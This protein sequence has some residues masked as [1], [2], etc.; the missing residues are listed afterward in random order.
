MSTRSLLGVPSPCVDVCRM[1]ETRGL[2]LGCH[3]TLDEIATWST[4]PDAAK[5]AVWA[6]LPGRAAAASAAGASTP[7]VPGLPGAPR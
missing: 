5:K 7:S 6:Q 3:R 1:D 2:C 4:L